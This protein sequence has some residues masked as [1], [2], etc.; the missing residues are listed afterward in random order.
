MTVLRTGS[1]KFCQRAIVAYTPQG[2]TFENSRGNG[3][4][5]EYIRV[6]WDILERDVIEANAMGSIIHS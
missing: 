4:H 3:G 6:T 5:D 1:A 2:V